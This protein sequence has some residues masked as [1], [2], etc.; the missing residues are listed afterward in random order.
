MSYETDAA[1]YVEE[2]EGY[3]RVTGEDGSPLAYTVLASADLSQWS[4]KPGSATLGLYS[5]NGTVFH[6]GTTEWLQCLVPGGDPVVKGITHNVFQRLRQRVPWDWEDIGHADFGAAMTALGGRL[7]IATTENKL[8]M[9]HPVGAEVVWRHIGHA[10]NVIAMAA[11]ADTLYCV[12]SDNQL[13]WREPVEFNVNW[14]P[15]GAGP[16][17][18]RSLAAAGATLYA[19]DAAGQLWRTA[20]RRAAPAWHLMTG[21]TPDPTVKAMTAY[22]DILLASTDDN[23][24]LRTPSD[25]AAD[26]LTPQRGWAPVWHCNFSVGLAVVEWMLFVATWQNRLWRLDLAGLR[27]P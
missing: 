5:R 8:W 26:E 19:T 13:W 2:P 23:R 3:P 25:F 12:T 21:F 9:R 1:G 15:I 11:R 14:T 10:N 27:Q 20:A 22:A 6:A 7:F 17:N 24:L 18:T 16:P 4:G